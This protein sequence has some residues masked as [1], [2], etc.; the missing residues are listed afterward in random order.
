M[1]KKLRLNEER[2][3]ELTLLERIIR[4]EE[5]LKALRELEGKRFESLIREMNARFESL[6]KR[7][8]FMQ[9]L[10]TAGFAFLGVLL[11]LLK[12]L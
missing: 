4:V 7:M 10:I 8:N 12:F 6:E 5:E 2:L 11:A 9:W 3:K 1:E